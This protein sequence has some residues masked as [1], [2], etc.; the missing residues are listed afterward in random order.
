MT[1]QGTEP[2]PRPPRNLVLCL[3]G[4]AGAVSRKNSDSNVVRLYGLLEQSRPDLQRTYYDP[5]VG[6]FASSAAWTPLARGLSRVAG[7]V[8]GGGMRHNLG[9]AYTWLMHEYLPGDRLYIFGFSRGAFTARALCGMLYRVGILRPGSENLVPYVVAQYARRGGEERIDW[10]AVDRHSEMFAYAVKGRRSVPVQYLGLWDSVK[11]LGVARLAPRWPYTRSTPNVAHIR[12]AVAIDETRRPFVEYLSRVDVAK[13]R[14]DQVWFTGVHCDVGGTFADDARLSTITLAW[15]VRGAID[16][17][18]RVRTR[19]WANVQAGISK[20]D[21]AATAHRNSWG[22]TLLIPRRRP[23]PDDA[24]VHASVR[25]RMTALPGYRPRL[26]AG[27]R[28]TDEEW[29]CASA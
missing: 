3:D 1:A 16:D 14:L 24:L 2:S 7:L 8:W 5:G 11:A 4:T 26:P 23:I 17:A 6:T 13:V 20:G 9:E 27:V 28:W 15:M 21:A 29:V 19:V 10:E 18:L 12:H 22:W 25:E